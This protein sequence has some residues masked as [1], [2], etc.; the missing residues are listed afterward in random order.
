LAGELLPD[1]RDRGGGRRPDHV[2]FEIAGDVP[3]HYLFT[4]LRRQ[5][6][7]AVNQGER[8]AERYLNEYETLWR[9]P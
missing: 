9:L 8:D 3:V 2:L 5:V 6:Q 1:A 4:F 7:R